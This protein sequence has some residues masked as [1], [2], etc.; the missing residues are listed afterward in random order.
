VSA[1]FEGSSIDSL[2]ARSGVNRT[3]IITDLDRRGVQR[4]KVVRKMTDRMVQRAATR[5][6]KG[7]SL[8]VVAAR[9]DVDARTLGKEFERRQWDPR[10]DES[11][12]RAA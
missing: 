12:R 11:R 7:E 8:K 10:E 3:T 2:A 9:Y 6:R 4:R 5:Y 1:Y